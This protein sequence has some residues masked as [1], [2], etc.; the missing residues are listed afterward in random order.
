MSKSKPSVPRQLKA[1]KSLREHYRE[2]MRRA[3]LNALFSKDRK[4]YDKL[5]AEA[6]GLLVDF[7]RNL[8]TR[9]TMRLLA[10]LAREAGVEGFRERMFAGE[11]INNTEGRAVLHAALRA[12]RE[13][14]FHVGTQ[15]A[16]ADVHAVLDAMLSFVDRVH[17]GEY[18]G[19]GCGEPFSDVVNIGIGGSDLGIVMA[20]DALTHY[21]NPAIRLHCVS[22]V[23]GTQL[24]D[25]L[26]QVDP[27]RTLFVVCSKTFTTLET[28]TNART[29]RE[30]L[31]ARI[32]EEAVPTHFAAVST[33]QAA[34]DAFGISPENRFGFWDWVGGRYSIWSSVG[35]ALALFVGSDNF[36]HFLA[37][38][39]A[40]DR[41]FR[42]AP[43]EENLP[44]ILAGLSVWYNDFFGAETQAILPYDG[45]LGR[46]PAFLQQLHMESNGK[47]V[48]R[49]GSPQRVPTGTIIWGE[50][51]NNAQHSF[52]QLLHQGTRLVPVD[53]LAPVNG[54]GTWQVQQDLALA[55][56]LAQAQALMQG[57]DEKTVRADLQRGGLQA[58]QVDALAPHKVHAGNRP[59]TL[60]LFERLDPQ[61][62]GSL[63]ALYEHKVFVE[64]AIW[65]INS[66][67]QWG[68][69]LGKRLAKDLEDA[70]A[71]PSS[72]SGT[73]P[74]V[75]AA[76]AAI[77]RWRD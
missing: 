46:F 24:A 35:L 9:K 59:S 30:W 10:A 37:G 69:E 3:N 12:G 50:A 4:R 41:H 7:S 58:D 18:K 74:S 34:M 77:A 70:V 49:D 31:A 47:S 26:R 8:V 66:F 48:R 5:S 54:S 6:C 23:D 11:P 25:V 21:R 2:D 15:D 33:N 16:T 36:R 17:R 60:L 52:Y 51:G 29:A 14:W 45:R 43:L 22:N 20:R 67:D 39:R 65:S 73:D 76:L 32:G 1:W 57:Q 56:C 27:R 38:G 75:R 42:E 40:M 62:L 63:V 55:N 72:Y 53:F 44:A 19:Y 71:D 13:D 64:G 68:V 28:L 61:T